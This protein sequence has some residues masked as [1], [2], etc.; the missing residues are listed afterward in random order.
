[1]NSENFKTP[2]AALPPDFWRRW[3]ISLPRGCEI[4][5][6][7]LGGRGTVEPHAFALMMT[8]LLGGLAGARLCAV[9]LC[10]R[11]L[12]II[13]RFG[14]E[15]ASK[16]IFAPPAG[17]GLLVHHP[18]LRVL[19][20]ADFRVEDTAVLVPSRRPSSVSEHA[21]GGDTTSFPTSRPSRS[22]GRCLC[23]SRCEWKMGGKSVVGPSP[24][25]WGSAWVDVPCVYLRP[26]ETI[27]FIYFDS[28]TV[29]A[30]PV[31]I[32]QALYNGSMTGGV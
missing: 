10:P 14:K 27:D 30:S 32:D 26:A 12:L 15:V 9:G 2:Y 20:L 29:E 17:G 28:E 1:M 21:I 25:V 24:G 22:P 4:I 11:T 3:H 5:F 16:A 18:I 13:H 6:I 8:M 19:Y 31:S 7:P 23:S